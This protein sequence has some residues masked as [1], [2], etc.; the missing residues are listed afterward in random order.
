[1]TREQ[2]MDLMIPLSNQFR[3]EGIKHLFVAIDEKAKTMA[4]TDNAGSEQG[5]VDLLITV[6]IGIHDS[7]EQFGSLYEPHF[8]KVITALRIIFS[9]F[10]Q[11]ALADQTMNVPKTSV[12]DI[13]YASKR[14]KKVAK[15]AKATRA[16]PVPKQQVMSDNVAACIVAMYEE[17][18]RYHDA[19]NDNWL[20]DFYFTHGRII[21]AAQTKVRRSSLSQTD[22]E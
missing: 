11:P 22:G 2:L 12:H 15:L 19:S 17:L 1:M 7:A 21:E 10:K 18:K 16:I 6:A 8:A 5:A 13:I 9:D 4:M 3:Q 20:R 14:T